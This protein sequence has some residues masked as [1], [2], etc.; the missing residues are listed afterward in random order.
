MQLGEGQPYVGY[1][2]EE[3]YYFD[4]YSHFSIHEEM[5]K[6]KVRTKA[7]MRAILDNP[8][9]FK[10]KVVLDI[11]SGTGI[12]SIFAGNIPPIQPKAEHATLRD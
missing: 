2:K 1:V 6:D 3:D 7:Y 9:L 12:L 8:N 4:G 5:L 11:G 10:D